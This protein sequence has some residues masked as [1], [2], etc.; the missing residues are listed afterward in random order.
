VTGYASHQL[1]STIALVGSTQAPALV[2]GEGPTEAAQYRNEPAGYDA[3]IIRQY[4]QPKLL[5]AGAIRK[6]TGVHA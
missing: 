6:L 5:I 4:L 1:T 2:L 3:Y